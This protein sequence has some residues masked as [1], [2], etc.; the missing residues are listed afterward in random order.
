MVLFIVSKAV[1]WFAF[2]RLPVA[3]EQSLISVLVG[4]RKNQGN[5]CRSGAGSTHAGCHR[6]SQPGDPGPMA[7]ARAVRLRHLATEPEEPM[8]Q[9][10]QPR[11]FSPAQRRRDALWSSATVVPGTAQMARVWFPGAER[12]LQAS[13]SRHQ[14]QSQ[15]EH[16]FSNKTHCK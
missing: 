11:I 8:L 16:L 12:N 15:N 13:Y 1:A 2:C 14:V 9:H 10:L 7:Q 4:E 3:S 6:P 5:F